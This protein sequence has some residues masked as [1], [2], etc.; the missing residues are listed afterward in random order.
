MIIN[1]VG[2]V[3]EWLTSKYDTGDGGLDN[4]GYKSVRSG[5]TTAGKI[6]HGYKR[7]SSTIGNVVGK[8]EGGRA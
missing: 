3:R 7:S 6:M 4:V 1:I 5:G 2:Q 8:E